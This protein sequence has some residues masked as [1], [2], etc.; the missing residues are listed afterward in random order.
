MSANRFPGYG[1]P[2]AVA[3][4]YLAEYGASAEW[5]LRET[6][7]ETYRQR[8]LYRHREGDGLEAQAWDLRLSTITRARRLLRALRP[9]ER[10]EEK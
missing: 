9:V 3:R 10:P 4:W 1:C 7:Q 5:Q 2:V 6:A 8:E